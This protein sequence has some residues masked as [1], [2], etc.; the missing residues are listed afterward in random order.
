M[1]KSEQLSKKGKKPLFSVQHIFLFTC[2]GHHTQ[3]LLVC[4]FNKKRDMVKQKMLF[5]GKNI[6]FVN[7][8][9]V[10][11]RLSRCDVY[12][13][14]GFWVIWNR[15]KMNI[16]SVFLSLKVL[17]YFVLLRTFGSIIHDNMLSVT[18]CQHSRIVKDDTGYWR[19][20]FVL[21]LKNEWSMD[22]TYIH[23]THIKKEILI[24]KF[25]R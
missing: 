6:E 13:D 14:D 24:Y 4:S 3:F 12:A 18:G 15:F 19:F 23:Y 25:L 16:K 7:N 22:Y 5:V 20:D 9:L 2:H 11:F 17:I 1:W 8:I 21:F 10:R